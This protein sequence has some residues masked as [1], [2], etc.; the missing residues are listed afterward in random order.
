MT[1][2][3]QLLAEYVRN[4]SE[5]AFRELVTR[6]LDLVYSVAFRSVE[7]DAH[8]AQDVA[9]TVFMDLA[10]L[11]RTFSPE[12]MLGGWLHRHTCFVAANTMRAERRR[13]SRER[14]AVEMNA[15][16]DDPQVNLTLIAPVLDA[17]ID[18]LGDDDRTAVLL[19]FYEQRDFRSVGE[20]LGSNEDAA[21]MRVNRALEKLHSLL[22]RRGVTTTAAALSVTLSTSAIGAAPAGLASTITAAVSA[23]G[24]A[25]MTTAATAGKVAGAAALQ[26]TAATVALIALFGAGVFEVHRAGQLTD[27]VRTDRQR[28][29]LVVNQVRQLQSERD[30]ATNSI[31]SLAREV[32]TLRGDSA[33]LLKLRGEATRLGKVSQELARFEANGGTVDKLEKEIAFGLKYPGPRWKSYLE[34]NALGALTRLKEAGELSPDQEQ[35][36][37]EL[38][39]KQADL[40]DEAMQQEFGGGQSPEEKDDFTQ[41][42]SNIV[43]QIDALLSPE[44]HAALDASR[45][46]EAEAMARMDADG[47]LWTIQQL[48][49]LSREQEQKIW[50]ILYDFALQRQGGDAPVAAEEMD[51]LA[52]VLSPEQLD[53]YCKAKKERS[54]RMIVTG[55][56]K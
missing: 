17:A 15:L 2:A 34:Q 29:D 22:K 49:G 39:L 5:A 3:Q 55:M 42:D 12:V 18:E 6:Y 45:G 1:N 32:A 38:L 50:P 27:Q 47:D 56:K 54:V 14:Q 7:G 37:H 20:V 43:A 10:R 8:R 16:H 30:D 25:V 23:S 13:Q 33:E 52:T 48:S 41:A 26:K 11:A 4:G 19:R 21:R 31:A 28:R 9:Q 35:S 46:R 40:R 53:Q 24:V 36:A 51:A 44:Q